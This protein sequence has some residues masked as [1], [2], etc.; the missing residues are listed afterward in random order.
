MAGP[1]DW[2]L[3]DGA[4]PTTLLV[5]GVGATLYL[6][7]DRDRPWWTWKLPLAVGVTVALTILVGLFVNK[8]W[9][10]FPDDLPTDVLAWIGVGILGV[11]LAVARFATMGWKGRTAAVAGALALILLAANQVN[12]HFQQYPTLRA[13]L[14]PWL[15]ESTDFNKASDKGKNNGLFVAPPGKMLAD[16][17]TAPA[18]LPAKG[19]I[20]EVT[21]PATVSHFSARSGWV[22]LP[23]AYQATPRPQLPLLVLYAGQPGSPRDW[24]D[25]GGLQDVMDSYATAHHGLAPVVLLPD[26]TGSAFGNPMCLDS[27]LGNSYTY[28]T[29]DVQNWVTKN[30]QVAPPTS[31]W[32]VGGYSY[33]GTCSLQMAVGDPSVYRTFL[34]MSGQQEPTLGSRSDTVNQAFGGDA[35]AFAKVNPIDVMATKKFPEVGGVIVAGE[36]DGEYTPGQKV[37][38]AACQKAGMNVSLV[39]LPGGH[40]WQVWRAGLTK[41]LPWIAERNGLAKG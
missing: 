36:S 2:S 18:G 29:T 26:S 24:I 6:L 8:W 25:A 41:E 32:S 5:V 4:V 39:V 34:D 7:A 28:L 19:T 14:G 10:P 21:I 30:L 3:I 35:A 9:K 16:V 23:P 15:S 27:K 12:R 40:S 31:G 1:L 33:G 13:A 22:Y 20:S 37:V 17:W 11:A 38:F